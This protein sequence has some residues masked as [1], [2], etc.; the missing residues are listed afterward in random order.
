MDSKTIAFIP[1]RGGSKGIPD[2]NVRAFCGKPLIYWNL[3]E[4]QDSIEIDQI[5]VATDSDRIKNIVHAF[6]LA[7]VEIYERL[8]ENAKDHSSTE[9][10]MLE[11]LKRN[12]RINLNDTFI[13]VQ[14]T[15]PLTK[16]IHFNEGLRVF[17]NK[18]IDSV[19]SVVRFK[20]FFWDLKGSSVNYDFRNRPRRQDFEGELMENG[21]FY[22][23]SVENILMNKNRL[24]GRIGFYEMPEYTSYELDELDDWDILEKLMYRYNIQNDKEEEEVKLFISDVDGVL[25]DSGMYYS[26]FGDEYKKF[27][28]RDGMAFQILRE[29]GIKTAIITSENT[30][31]VERRA[32]KMKIDYLFQGAYEFGKLE[33]AEEICSKLNISLKNVAYIGDDLNCLQLLSSV[34]IK[35]CPSDAEKIVK[36]IPQIHVLQ[37]KGGR[38][39]VREFVNLILG[40]DK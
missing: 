12:E 39:V 18:N 22:I 16:K 23:N 8:P 30:E 1:A 31:I 21:A 19:L 36:E 5:I 27:N 35:A 37:A 40:L 28:T 11:F 38:G 10:V 13:L 20:R 15:S 29:H 17:R 26:E 32:K 2:K 3:K 4:L 9:S 6:G 25:T 33:A 7:K 34:G 14:A 24:S